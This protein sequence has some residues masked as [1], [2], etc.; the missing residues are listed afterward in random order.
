MNTSEFAEWLRERIGL[1]SQEADA[2]RG[3]PKNPYRCGYMRGIQMGL[4]GALDQ[5]ATLDS[6]HDL[7][8]TKG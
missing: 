5:L 6:S 2:L 4:Q 7:P 3:D 8:S 1:F